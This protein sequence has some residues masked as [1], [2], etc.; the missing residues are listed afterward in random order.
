MTVN[1]YAN[2][3]DPHGRNEVFGLYPGWCKRGSLG[4][5][6]ANHP[7]ISHPILLTRGRWRWQCPC[8]GEVYEYA[9]EDRMALKSRCCREQMEVSTRTPSSEENTPQSPSG[10]ATP[11]LG[12]DP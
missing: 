4:S 7:I 5:H 12:N 2:F 1:G 8:C 3:D 9:V 10:R 6:S 11:F